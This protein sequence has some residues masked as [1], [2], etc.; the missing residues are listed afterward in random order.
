MNILNIYQSII[1]LQKKKYVNPRCAAQLEHTHVTSS[2]TEA[3]PGPLWVSTPKGSHYPDFQYHRLIFLIFELDINGIIQHVLF[4][5]KIGVFFF[6]TAK[7]ILA[8]SEL[9]ET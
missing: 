2:I 3:S 8:I 6:L 1:C 9:F 5:C 7:L 4:V